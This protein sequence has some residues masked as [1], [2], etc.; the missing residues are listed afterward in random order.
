MAVQKL[1]KPATNMFIRKRASDDRGRNP[2]PWRELRHHSGRLLSYQHA[3][4]VLWDSGHMWPELFENFEVAYASSCSR[5]P[6]PL[7]T[8]PQTASA[9]IGRIVTADDKSR[10][11][12]LAEELQ[13]KFEL[14]AVVE[15]LWTKNSFRPV[16]H[17]EILLLN[18][19]ENNGG[20]RPPRFF[21][22]WQYIG[23]SK[24]TCRLCE[25]YISS[26]PSGVQVRSPHKNLYANWRMPDHADVHDFRGEE[27]ALRK[28]HEI[29]QSVAS[30]VRQD[31]LRTLSEKVTD[32]RPH[33]SNTL[34]SFAL[35]RD[36]ASGGVRIGDTSPRA[37]SSL[38][39]W[40]TL[41]TE[42]ETRDEGE[43][44]SE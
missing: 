8:S 23:S 15:T 27:D 3:V 34:S 39:E 40:S 16:V 43:V 13:H 19:L 17:A 5:H 36:L 38:D 26:H 22:N 14:D 42:N 29:M 10:Y 32:T 2:V 7:K 11:L 9:I 20:T 6:N 1:Q 24:P 30:R 37:E 35:R 33:D 18:W 41:G 31:A 44:N 25:Y 12:A 4:E 28:R 21:N